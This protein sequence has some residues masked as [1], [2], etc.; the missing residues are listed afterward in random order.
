MIHKSIDYHE[1][2]DKHLIIF[3]FDETICHNPDAKVYI[4]NKK[5]SEMIEMTPTDY[6]EWRATGEY[7]KDPDKWDM[8]FK[9]YRSYPHGGKPITK[10]VEKL[11]HYSSHD[12]YIVALVTGRDNLA[13]PKQWMNDFYIPVKNMTLMCCGNPDKRNCYRSLINTFGPMHVT[14]YED[15]IEC[16][17]QCEEICEIFNIPFSGVL[18]ENEKTS[19]NW[20]KNELRR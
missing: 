9:E 18:V 16:I 12:H 2:Y 5:T 13:G 3:D 1:Q 19:I 20:R 11:K 8:D 10:I 15:S 4:G 17:K 7:E 14:I 6:S